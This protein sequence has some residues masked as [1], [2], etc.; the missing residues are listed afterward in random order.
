MQPVED[1][2]VGGDERRLVAITARQIL[3]GYNA[4][5]ITFHWLNQQ[6]LAVIVSKISALY[7]LGNKW[8]KFERF[9]GRFVVEYEI[10]TR[11]FFILSDKIKSA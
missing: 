7:N 5:G 4:A 9:V 10:N 8:P 3:R 11:D 2:W 1:I 6:N